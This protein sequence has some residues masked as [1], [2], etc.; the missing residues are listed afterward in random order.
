MKGVVFD[1]SIWIEFLKGNPKF[2]D[3][4]QELLE[5]DR[6]FGLELIFAEL[7]QGAK[8]NREI[9][10]I[11]AYAS[12]VPTLDEPYLIIESGLMS[13][14]YNYINDGV[15]LIDAVIL[16]AAKKNDLQVWTLDKKLRKVSGYDLLF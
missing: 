6:V 15:G 3:T 7:L 12:L 10:T 14:K 5:K 11:L 4:C 2:F 13:Q 9:D 8:G 1:T 16:K